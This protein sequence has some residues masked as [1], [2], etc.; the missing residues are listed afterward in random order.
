MIRYSLSCQQSHSFDGW[1]CNSDAFDE[2]VTQNQVSCPLCGT[3]S[4]SKA[5][6]A[7]NIATRDSGRKMDL[8]GDQEQKNVRALMRK[9]R[10]YV[11]ANADYVGERFAE[12]ARNIHHEESESRGIYGEATF[13][14]IK[15]LHEEG[16]ECHRLPQLPDDQN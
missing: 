5:L 2:Q 13:E 6:M 16:I 11:T 1:F 15:E 12:E 4:V 14:D 3:T 8:G 7:P 10:E 9:V